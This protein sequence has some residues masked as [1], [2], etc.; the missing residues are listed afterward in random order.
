MSAA[1]FPDVVLRTDRLTLRPFGESDIDAVVVAGQDPVTQKWLPLPAPYTHEHARNWCCEHAP[2][3]RTSGQGLVL[4]LEAGG[5]LVGAIDLKSTDWAARTTEIGY[6]TAPHAR[7]QG[8]MTEAV[9]AL[10]TWALQDMGFARVEVRVAEQNAASQ[11][12]AQKAGFV[13]EGVARSAGHVHGGRVDMLISSLV[14]ADLG[15]PE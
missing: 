7:G 2:S 3:I 14:R 13:P 6:W 10:A 9:R 1:V 8:Y 4:A 11:R 15:L 12:V 5:V